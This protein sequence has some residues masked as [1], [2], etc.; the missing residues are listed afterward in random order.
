MPDLFGGFE[1]GDSSLEDDEAMVDV[2]EDIVLTKP[3]MELLNKLVVS[4]ELTLVEMDQV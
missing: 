3:E 4:D 2:P 1:T